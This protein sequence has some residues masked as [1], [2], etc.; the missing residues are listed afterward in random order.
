LYEKAA[1]AMKT[2]WNGTYFNSVE[3]DHP[4]KRECRMILLDSLNNVVAVYMRAKR[5][6]KARQA[7][8]AVLTEDSKNPKALLRN[9][10]SY[11][12]DPAMSLEEK[13][14]ALCKAEKVIV[15]KDKEEVELRKLRA[16]WKKKNLAA[17]ASA[18]SE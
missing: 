6:E 9:A 16:Q 1:K 17:G 13:D 3:E 7:A 8:S 5:W 11:M 14:A 18:S 10:K 15:Y 4:Q 2:L 12:L